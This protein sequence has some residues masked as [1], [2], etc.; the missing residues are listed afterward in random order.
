MNCNT[1]PGLNAE[2][3]AARLARHGSNRLFTP[4]PVRFWRIAAEHCRK[5]GIF[6]AT[7]ITDFGIH[8]ASY[9]RPF[10]GTTLES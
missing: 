5:L 6:C 7:V 9:D 1:D 8:G 10:M 4:A 3:A 2:E